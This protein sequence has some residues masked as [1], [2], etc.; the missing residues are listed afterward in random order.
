[1]VSIGPAI[2]HPA[3]FMSK[4]A[5]EV[6]FLMD[7]AAQSIKDGFSI[8]IL[9]GTIFVEIFRSSSSCA[10]FLNPANT[11]QSSFIA[12]ASNKALPIPEVAPVI[13]TV[14]FS[15]SIA[16]NPYKNRTTV[17]TMPMPTSI[18]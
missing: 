8:S 5:L 18:L 12:Y 15:L 7:N 6:C 16:I 13:I 10:G 4:S 17:N 11:L 1:M 14:L 3:A 2:T 9:N